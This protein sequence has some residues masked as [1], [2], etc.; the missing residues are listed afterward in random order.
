MCAGTAGFLETLP[1]YRQNDRQIQPLY[2]VALK[3][4]D[5]SGLGWEA[6]GIVPM[7]LL[8]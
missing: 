8:V 7:A 2:P 1:G 5:D 3:M 6:A 4:T